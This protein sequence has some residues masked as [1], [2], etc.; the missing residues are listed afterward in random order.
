LAIKL[1]VQAEAMD[2]PS[3]RADLRKTYG[4][5][6]AAIRSGKQKEV[7]EQLRV[8]GELIEDGASTD[9]VVQDL[10]VH[11]DRR[12]NRAGRVAE[13]ESK[14]GGVVTVTELGAV[15]RQWLEVLE[16][17]LPSEEY[18]RVLPELRR[19]TASP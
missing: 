19:M 11:L 13:Q 16:R 9:Q 7:G 12:A 4:L 6:R 1:V 17:V 5:L 10:I 8:L 3:W 15:M 14:T 2:S 18:Y